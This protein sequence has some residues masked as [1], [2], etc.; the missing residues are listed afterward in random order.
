MLEA[1]RDGLPHHLRDRPICEIERG[2]GDRGW[3]I[4]MHSGAFAMLTT[5]ATLRTLPQHKITPALREAG[6]DEPE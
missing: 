6:I 5:V 1:I 2:D 3:L 4:K